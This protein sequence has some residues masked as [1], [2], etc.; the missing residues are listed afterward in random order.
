MKVNL[1]H[2]SKENMVMRLAKC[3][4]NNKINSVNVV[5][6]M[7]SLGSWR[8]KTLVEEEAYGAYWMSCE[9]IFIPSILVKAT[10]YP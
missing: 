8:R 1:E 9:K 7:R 6:W 10:C 4:I 5:L 2:L 3:L